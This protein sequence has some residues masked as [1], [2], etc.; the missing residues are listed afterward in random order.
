MTLYELTPEPNQ[1]FFIEYE[2]ERLEMRRRYLPAIRSWI[3]DIVGVVEGIRLTPNVPI[4][5]AYGYPGIV[6]FDRWPEIGRDVSETVI[7]YLEPE[8]RVMSY[9]VDL[10]RLYRNSLGETESL[11]NVGARKLPPEVV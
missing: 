10:S 5:T 11:R 6:F 1:R 7:A 9:I 8:E 4:F 2:G 3:A